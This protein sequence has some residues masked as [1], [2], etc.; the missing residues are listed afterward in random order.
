M[1]RDVSAIWYEYEEVSQTDSP[2]F[3]IYLERVRE[4]IR[5]MKGMIDDVKRLRPHVKTHKILEIISLLRNEGIE[6]FKCATIAEAEMVAMAGGKDILLAYQPVGPKVER[7]CKLMKQYPLSSFSCL[8][9]DREA[10][11]YISKVAKEN[12]LTI[13]VYL[14]LNVGMNRTGITVGD[15]AFLLYMSASRLEGL[16]VIG[17]HAYDGHI[18]NE[19]FEERVKICN[20]SFEQVGNLKNRIIESGLRK[21]VIVAGGTPTFQIHANRGEVEC[22]PGTF[23][24]WDKGYEATLSEQKFLHAALVLCRIISIPSTNKICVDLGHK[25]IASENELSKRVFFLNAPDLKVVGHSEEHLIVEVP[26]SSEYKVGDV[27]YGLPYHICPTCA[28]YDKALVIEEGKV[29]GEWKIIGRNRKIN[30]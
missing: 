14:D 18:R 2:S 9:D 27:L 26:A 29:V 1:N 3:I 19:S 21:P 28:L 22:S 4:N 16:E 23:I 24:F 13:P 25:A 10:V 8:F 5:I 7:L 30:F 6:K 17:L 20:Q 12:R 11:E 15:E